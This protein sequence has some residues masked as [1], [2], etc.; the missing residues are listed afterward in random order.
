MIRK[1][2][3]IIPKNTDY[4]VHAAATKIVPTAETNPEECVK[5]NILGTINLIQ[6]CKEKIKRIIGLSTDKACNQ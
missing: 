3:L 5:T 1:T 2:I 4:V 6:V